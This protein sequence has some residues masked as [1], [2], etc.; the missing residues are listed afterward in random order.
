[1]D[2]L[3]QVNVVAGCVLK[4]GDKYLLVQEQKPKAYGLWSF[5]GGRVH[6]GES[7]E[8]AAK[9]EVFEETGFVVEI[10]SRIGINHDSV[11][12]PVM[13]AYSAV[14]KSG[15]LVIR[16][17]EILDAGWFTLAEVNQMKQDGKLRAS[18][19]FECI[20]ANQSA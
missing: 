7:L 9:R 5:P 2:E 6:T 4:D 1:M 8:E 15:E 11:D 20:A 19:V 3:L 14:V 12:R 16:A 13:H 17:G 10:S 18:W